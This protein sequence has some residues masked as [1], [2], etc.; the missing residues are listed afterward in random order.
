[1]DVQTAIIPHAALAKLDSHFTK[2]Y[3]KLHIVIVGGTDICQICSSLFMYAG[4]FKKSRKNY[5]WRKI[6]RG[7][8]YEV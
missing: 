3:N 6:K 2:G 5:Q 8:F 7:K 1:M 4:N